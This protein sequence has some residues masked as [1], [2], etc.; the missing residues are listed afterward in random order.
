MNKLK[1]SL[2]H[3]G[4]TTGELENNKKLLLKSLELCSQIKSDWVISPELWVCGYSFERII[5][6]EWINVQPDQWMNMLCSEVSQRN[7]NLFLSMP[8]KDPYSNLLHNSVFVINRKG[9]IIGKYRKIKVLPQSEGWSSPGNEIKSIV[10]DAEKVGILICADA[11]R[12]QLADE[13][14]KQ[15][16]TI[17]ICPSAWGPGDCAPNGEWELRSQEVGVPLIVC[18]RTGTDLDVVD[19]TGSESIVAIEGQRVLSASPQESTILSFDIDIDNR[20]ILSDEF[21][22]TAIN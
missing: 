2:L 4:P 13:Y 19:W 8:E 9:Q 11:Y 20:E 12:P 17:L 18:N 16:V 5:G 3:L 15:E 10:V 14:H 21:T 22:L 1:I 6:K 7:F